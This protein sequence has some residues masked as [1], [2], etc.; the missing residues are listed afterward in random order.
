MS[1]RA[2]RLML[3]VVASIASGPAWAEDPVP[4]A[5]SSAVRA[6]PGSS[7]AA[8]AAGPAARLR[9]SHRVD[10]I[11]PGERVESVIDRMRAGAPVSPAVSPD[12]AAPAG[13]PP[14]GGP[15]SRV[16]P[17]MRAP[18]RG[19]RPPGDGRAGQGAGPPGIPGPQPPTRGDGPLPDRHP[20]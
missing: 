14:A 12:R 20:R 7:A 4:P 13:A 19:S 6:A 9:A 17:P 11:A 16:A 15:S 8:P 1:A 3:L 2:A 5:T 10:V 18:D